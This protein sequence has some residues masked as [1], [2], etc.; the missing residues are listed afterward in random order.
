MQKLIFTIFIILLGISAVWAEKKDKHRVIL[1]GKLAGVEGTCWINYKD[2]VGNYA[3]HCFE[4]KDGILQTEFDV[5]YPQVVSVVLGKRFLKSLEDGGVVPCNSAYLM[6]VAIPGQHLKVNGEMKQDFVDV[7]PSGDSENNIFR[8]YTSALHPKL[9][10]SVNLN[11]K[12][13]LDESLSAEQRQ[14]YCQQL[15]QYD[16]EMQRIRLDFL[17]KYASSIGGLWLLNDMLM[18]EQLSVEEGETYLKK[19][20][21][22][23]WNTS[24]YT[25]IAAR[26]QGARAAIVGQLA[27]SIR[28]TR[29]Y[30]GKPF[31]MKEYKG[32]YVLVDFWGTWCVA[33]IQGMPEMKKF[34]ERHA[35]KLVIL[36]IA[37]ESNENKWRKYLGRSEWNWKQILSGDGEEDHVVRYDVHGFPTKLLIDPDGKILVRSIGEDPKFYKELEQLIK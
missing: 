32:K 19:I 37:K 35:D 24:Y 16:Q 9:N 11:I 8:K 18:R 28:S 26:I 7:Y 31:D 21:E 30:D 27:P 20:D 13:R 14:V 22:K 1:T 25:S 15:E 12:C 2:S 5:W 33:C 10:V 29:T 23:Y 3:R 36:G 6:F 4:M 17:N 34:A